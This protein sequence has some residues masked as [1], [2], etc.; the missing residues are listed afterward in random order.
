MENNVKYKIKRTLYYFPTR[1]IIN[2]N[3]ILNH[4]SI[5]TPYLSLSPSNRITETFNLP[6][7]YNIKKKYKE[8]TRNLI[9]F[10]RTKSNLINV[11]K[12]EYENFHKK[13]LEKKIKTNSNIGKSRFF[14]TLSQ[15]NN[16]LSETNNI[17]TYSNP[18]E[19][20]VKYKKRQFF[21][22][23]KK[24]KNNQ[25]LTPR[26]LSND[27][28]EFFKKRVISNVLKKRKRNSIEELNNKSE[29]INMRIFQLKLG[30]NLMDSFMQTNKDLLKFSRNEKEKEENKLD[31]IIIQKETLIDE[32]KKISETIEKKKNILNFYKSIADINK[33]FFGNTMEFITNPNFIDE[34]IN[35]RTNININLLNVLNDKKSSLFSIKNKLKNL[36]IVINQESI[37]EEKIKIKKNHLNDLKSKN[38]LLLKKKEYYLKERKNKNKQDKKIIFNFNTLNMKR[39]LKINREIHYNNMIYNSFPNS[40]LAK[41]LSDMIKNIRNV[42]PNLFILPSGMRNYEVDYILNLKYN[43]KN[44]EE[45]NK[46]IITMIIILERIWESLFIELK[47]DLLIP[48]NANFIR[49]EL[50]SIDKIKQNKNI[51]N[52]HLISNEIRENMIQSIIKKENK[53]ILKPKKKIN[54]YYSQINVFKKTVNK[55]NQQS[56]PIMDYINIIEG[57]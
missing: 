50:H 56:N 48:E 15:E 55:I 39:M 12:T 13:L 24:I 43:D 31:D 37:F 30:N 44:K 28:K 20:N 2:R 51:K 9:N 29:R 3:K 5:S 6:S 53:I 17:N 4:E 38:F 36:E 18:P 26:E 57:I 7:K 46:N 23:T 11:N 21:N 54:K 47:K 10:R 32:I 45:I 52:Y 42:S 14:I 49:Q 25:P 27:V 16:T 33:K 40:T 41:V 1:K 35:E 34:K 8:L 22:L 19:L